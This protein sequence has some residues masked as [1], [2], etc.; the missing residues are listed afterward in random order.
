MSRDELFSSLTLHGPITYFEANWILSLRFT[1]QINDLHLIEEGKIKTTWHAEDW[2]SA[3]EQMLT[4]KGEP[5]LEFPEEETYETLTE[6]PQAMTDFYTEYL[7]NAG[8]GS[9]FSGA[10]FSF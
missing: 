8:K 7:S 6:I 2:S 3:L 9:L 4:G 1:I 10:V 5:L